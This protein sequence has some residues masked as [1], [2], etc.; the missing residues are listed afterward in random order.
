VSNR[1]TRVPTESS[2]GDHSH[3]NNMTRVVCICAW[4]KAAHKGR[5]LPLAQ[6]VDG[7]VREAREWQQ[8]LEA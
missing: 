3:L 7:R 4:F 2:S 5:L 1:N 6:L 8:L